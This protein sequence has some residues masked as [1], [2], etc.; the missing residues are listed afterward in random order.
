MLHLLQGACLWHLLLLGVLPRG[1]LSYI[2]HRPSSPMRRLSTF[3]SLAHHV[4]WAPRAHLGSLRHLQDVHLGT[5][6][7]HWPSSFWNLIL[8][9]F[10]S[11][12]WRLKTIPTSWIPV[13][14]LLP[15][16]GICCTFLCSFIH[17]CPP[18]L[19]FHWQRFGGV[20]ISYP[21]DGICVSEVSFCFFLPSRLAADPHRI[22]L[23][24]RLWLWLSAHVPSS[25]CLAMRFPF[26]PGLVSCLV[27]L[28]PA[29]YSRTPSHMPMLAILP[30][31]S[32]PHVPLP[33]GQPLSTSV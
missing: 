27:N 4:S 7:P 17:I 2:H 3:L 30:P 11:K 19:Y 16:V 13:C 1:N 12:S 28:S 10:F 20:A 21:S 26:Q 25:Q 18:S 23:P 24:A 15:V 14:F 29:S 9:S 6:K 22:V 8:S 32:Q 31:C 5:F 33:P